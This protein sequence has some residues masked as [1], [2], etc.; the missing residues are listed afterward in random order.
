MA[1]PLCTREVGI[2]PAIGYLDPQATKINVAGLHRLLIEMELL[3]DGSLAESDVVFCE[4]PRYEHF[5]LLRDEQ[6]LRFRLNQIPVA[7]QRLHH[8]RWFSRQF[9]RRANVLRTYL[10]SCRRRL[11]GVW[12]EKPYNLDRGEGITFLRD[13]RWWRK[14]RHLLQR[15]LEDPWLVNGRKTEVRLIAKINDDGSVRVYREGLVRVALRPY[16]L[17]DLDPLIHNSNAPFQK[18]MG[19]EAIEQ[20]LLSDLSPDGKLL[21]A[22]VEIVNDTVATLRRKRLFRGTDDFEAMGYDFV[23]DRTGTP[24]L[25]EANRFPGLHFDQEVCTRFFNGMIRELYRGI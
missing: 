2:E 13:P 19:V 3:R 10:G 24:F 16:T 4:W 1:F 18:R 6:N 15:Y 12:V 7:S 14:K 23:V 25:L 17:E 11:R 20:H 8:K 21:D 22:M 5:R 9:K